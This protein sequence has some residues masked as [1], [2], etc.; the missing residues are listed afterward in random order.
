MRKAAIDGR[1]TWTVIRGTDAMRA[2]VDVMPPEP[3]PLQR[4]T[5]RVKA[6]MDPHGVLNPGRMYAGL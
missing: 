3:A 4:I 6:A 5:R 1:G 2:A